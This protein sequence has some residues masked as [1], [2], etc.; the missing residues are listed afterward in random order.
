MLSQSL[1][2][3]SHRSSAGELD[4]ETGLAPTTP[5]IPTTHTRTITAA[6]SAYTMPGISALTCL[7]DQLKLS[8]T[9]FGFLRFLADRN[10][11]LASLTNLND[12]LMQ[13][14]LHS[15][16]QFAKIWWTP[17]SVLS[18]ADSS[19][20]LQS[21][22]PQSK[23][24]SKSLSDSPGCAL[25]QNK[26]SWAQFHSFAQFFRCQRTVSS[27]GWAKLRGCCCLQGKHLLSTTAAQQGF[28]R[29]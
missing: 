2:R 3:W 8:T 1:G 16:G 20:K 24:V 26:L 25:A 29:S 17:L 13:V 18:S 21:E 12:Y 5:T 6:V 28:C 19:L 9:A 10:G 4:G 22:I 11:Y 23:Q 7:A 14:V 27:S 15:P